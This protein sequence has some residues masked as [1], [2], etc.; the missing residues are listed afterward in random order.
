M[1][2]SMGEIPLNPPLRK[3]NFDAA[4]DTLEEIGTFP[5]FVKGGQGGFLPIASATQIS[6]HNPATRYFGFSNEN[7]GRHLLGE[8]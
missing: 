4:P 6:P 7:S 3:G 2:N 1:F 5:P 8:E